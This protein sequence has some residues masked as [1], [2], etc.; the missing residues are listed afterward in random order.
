[1]TVEATPRPAIQRRTRTAS[2]CQEQGGDGCGE[3]A[4]QGDPGQMTRPMPPCVSGRFRVAQV[5][6]GAVLPDLNGG[7]VHEHEPAVEVPC[8]LGQAF[9]GACVVQVERDDG[10]GAARHAPQVAG[11]VQA[12]RPKDEFRHMPRG[13][14]GAFDRV[15]GT[16]FGENR[17]ERNTGTQNGM[18]RHRGVTD[19][20]H[21]SQDEAKSSGWPLGD[22]MANRRSS[23]PRAHRETLGRTVGPLR[24]Q[25]ENSGA[26]EPS[27]SPAE[28]YGR[29]G[30]GKR[31]VRVPPTTRTDDKPPRLQPSEPTAPRQPS[32][33]QRRRV[34][35]GHIRAGGIHDPHT[36]GRTSNHDDPR[37]PARPIEGKGPGQ[38]DFEEDTVSALPQR[39]G[40]TDRSERRNQAGRTA[41]RCQLQRI[42]ARPAGP[43][44]IDGHEHDDDLRM[45]RLLDA[46]ALRLVHPPI[47]FPSG[48]ARHVTPWVV[49]SDS[50][51]VPRLGLPHVRWRKER[52][53]LLARRRTRSPRAGCGTA[54]KRP[55]AG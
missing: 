40:D 7:D 12:E 2:Q 35:L 47:A 42:R 36:A 16:S 53:V 5:C 14:V 13:R 20:L 6:V 1:M 24:A 21:T 25:E 30:F 44:R 38:P 23:C 39:D 48:P 49:P 27:E 9:H 55:S 22:H 46:A 4:R 37:C 15:L 3:G 51:Y 50:E 8:D 32:G 26:T 18:S 11:R 45:A 19:G 52:T 41:S 10:H 54:S 31:K 34:P 33:A 17:R 28:V 29:A 43:A